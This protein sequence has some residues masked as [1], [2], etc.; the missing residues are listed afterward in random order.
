MLHVAALASHDFGLAETCA[1]K[2]PRVPGLG[3]AKRGRVLLPLTSKVGAGDPSGVAVVL[4]HPAFVVQWTRLGGRLRAA[5]ASSASTA[6][7]RHARDH[8]RSRP[9]RR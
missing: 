1:A 9:S 7:R 2:S 6:V 3:P 4:A 8:R 5:V